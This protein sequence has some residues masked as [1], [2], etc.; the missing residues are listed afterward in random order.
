M[1]LTF[2]FLTVVF[3][4]VSATAR[5]QTVS[6]NEKGVSLKRIFTVIEQ[7][8]GFVVFYNKEH[9]RNTVAVSVNVSN[10]PLKDLL[11][12]V[13]QHQPLTYEISQK[14]ILI[15]KKPDPPAAPATPATKA[16]RDTV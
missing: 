8:T 7:Q 14:N 12:M 13:L 1:K 4:H 9:L 11:G 2:L 15:R 16:E 3:L 5:S 10:M 6:L